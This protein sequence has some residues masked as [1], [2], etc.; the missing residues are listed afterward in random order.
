M[1]EQN[2]IK[3]KL[4]LHDI[5]PDNFLSLVLPSGITIQQ[6]FEDL[7]QNS[8]DRDSRY[9]HH[10]IRKRS[11]GIRHLHEPDEDLKTAQRYVSWLLQKYDRNG[12]S[13]AYSPKPLFT[14]QESFRRILRR[15][16]RFQTAINKLQ[17][18]HDGARIMISMDI[19]N[20]FPSIKAKHIRKM[21]ISLHTV[22]TCCRKYKIPLI[23]LVSMTNGLPQ[24]APSSPVISNLCMRKFDI[25]M[26]SMGWPY[27]RIRYSRYADDIQ[28]S[29]S[30]PYISKRFWKEWINDIF[31]C[32]NKAVA[33]EGMRF[34]KHKSKV[35]LSGINRISALG[36]VFGVDISRRTMA[37]RISGIGSKKYKQ[38]KGWIH[39]VMNY[40]CDKKELETLFATLSYAAHLDIIR[41]RKLL[42][43]KDIE[44]LEDIAKEKQSHA[45]LSSQIKRAVREKESA[46]SF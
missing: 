42:S 35:M 16:R 21:L 18:I 19:K 4:R 11:G 45:R 2:Q 33:V 1:M 30:M 5:T 6:L 27:G 34:N 29:S 46:D 38:Y 8:N 3:K 32:A 37:R 26:S 12:H 14:T 10:M 28:L 17:S 44:I 7:Q 36:V 20:F 9:T 22:D 41:V 39:K 40:E 31:K 25:T 15:S 43:S 24:G 23:P 13:L